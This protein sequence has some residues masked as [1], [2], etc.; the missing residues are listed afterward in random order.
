MNVNI[1]SLRIGSYYN[2]DTYAPAVL[3]TN[4]KKLKLE[5]ILNYQKARQEANVDLLA[6]RVLPYLPKTSPSGDPLTEDHT[7]Y[8]YYLFRDALSNLRPIVLAQPWIITNEDNEVEQVSSLSA[9]IEISN[10]TD[11]RIGTIR[12]QLML[13]GAEFKI[14]LEDDV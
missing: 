12:K 14:R 13:L 2:L 7:R 5:A 1:S 8:T 10:T 9:I 4:F 11:E 3:R 6:R